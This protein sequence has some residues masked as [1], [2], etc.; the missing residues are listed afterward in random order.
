MPKRKLTAEQVRE[1]RE[2]PKGLSYPQLAK[3]YSVHRNTVVL[4]RTGATWGRVNDVKKA[5]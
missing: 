3:R 5:G 4:A 1:I 2:N